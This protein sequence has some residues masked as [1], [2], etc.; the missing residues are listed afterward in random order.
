MSGIPS[1]NRKSFIRLNIQKGGRWAPSNKT[2]QREMQTSLSAPEVPGTL[3]DVTFMRLPE[4]KLVTGLSKTTIYELI[5]AKTFPAPVRL[6]PR[7]VAWVKAEIRD[8][9]VGRVQ[10]SRSAA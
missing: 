6:G 5:R 10:A 7:S 1:G 8:W 2:P 9:A 4:V 3:D